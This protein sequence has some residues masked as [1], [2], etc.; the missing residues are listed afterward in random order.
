MFRVEAEVDMA[1][2]HW[3]F[4]ENWNADFSPHETG[5]EKAD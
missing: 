1:A 2:P 4:K 3:D 5:V